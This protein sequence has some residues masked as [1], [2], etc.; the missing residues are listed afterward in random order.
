MFN[1]ATTDRKDFKAGKVIGGVGMGDHHSYKILY[2]GPDPASNNRILIKK[3]F[4]AN[5][6][7]YFYEDV[8]IDV[9]NKSVHTKSHQLIHDLKENLDNEELSIRLKHRGASNIHGFSLF[10]KPLQSG[11]NHL[12]I[13]E[14]SR[15]KVTNRWSELFNNYF[16]RRDGFNYIK[17]RWYAN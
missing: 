16:I 12:S 15:W 6:N 14:N 3:V 17:S 7:T 11:R 13:I 5:L 10:W 2:A 8:R 4:R 1:L 9:V